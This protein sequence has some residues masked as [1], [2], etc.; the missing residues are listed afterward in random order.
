MVGRDGERAPGRGNSLGTEMGM[1]E[2]EEERQSRRVRSWGM[3]ITWK[4]VRS[5]LAASV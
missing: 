2:T 3:K 5:L 1:T 4:T